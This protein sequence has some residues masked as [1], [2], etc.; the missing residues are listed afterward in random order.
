MK[1]KFG[2]NKK[3]LSQSINIIVDEAKAGAD[4]IGGTLK[5]TVHGALNSRKNVVMVRLNESSLAR[6]D[7][8]VETGILNS[9]SEAA[10]Y[11]I[12][13][14]IISKQELFDRISKK[15]SEIREAKKELRD[16]L[17]D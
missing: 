12:G 16:L 2:E 9:R 17:V 8:L 13:E 7:D 3:P 6:L 1:E 5:N 14:G 10:A 11:L 15:I 4:V